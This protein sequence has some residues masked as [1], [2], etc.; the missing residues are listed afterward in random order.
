MVSGIEI[1][2]QVFGRA[3]GRCLCLNLLRRCNLP[4]RERL[5]HFSLCC[6]PLLLHVYIFFYRRRRRIEA[7]F[8][9]LTKAT[10]EFS[11]LVVAQILRYS[12]QHPEI[13]RPSSQLRI[14][15]NSTSQ[16]DVR[17]GRAGL[18]NLFYQR[19]LFVLATAV[20]PRREGRTGR[21]A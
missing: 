16:P 10:I 20:F 13:L 14:L 5:L 3:V 17:A 2:L 7:C 15:Y 4:Q 1:K 9:C 11:Y 8:R 6:G 19:R 18:P 12:S 21:I